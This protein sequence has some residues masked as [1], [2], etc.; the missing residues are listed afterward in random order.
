MVMSSDGVD[1]SLKNRN[2]VYTA[3][4]LSS[5][6]SV[7]SALQTIAQWPEADKDN[8][9]LVHVCF[10]PG[11]AWPLP[12]KAAVAEPLAGL[13][14]VDTDAVPTDV[15]FENEP[16]K[17]KSAPA[18]QGGP[19]LSLRKAKRLGQVDDGSAGDSAH[20]G[21]DEGNRDVSAEPRADPNLRLVMAGFFATGVLAG[22]ILCFTAIWLG[23]HR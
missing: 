20:A 17:L 13:V 18:A 2:T 9:S 15:Q 1:R 21:A 19:V 11:A 5:G 3:L 4:D 23:S 10:P 16:Q 22:I 6:K 8:M 14:M 7:H 12:D